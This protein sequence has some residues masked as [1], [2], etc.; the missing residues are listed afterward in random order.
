MSRTPKREEI[1]FWLVVIQTVC[2]VA[3][4][5]KDLGYWLASLIKAH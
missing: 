1:V 2:T 3:T 4:T 5:A